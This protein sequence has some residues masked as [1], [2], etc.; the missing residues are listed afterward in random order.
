MSAMTEEE[1]IEF[2]K[3]K[4]IQENKERGYKPI[5]FTLDEWVDQIPPVYKIYRVEHETDKAILIRCIYDY[6]EYEG[7]QAYQNWYPK[8]AIHFKEV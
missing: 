7:Y 3:Q 5:D 8:K 1:R 6:S 2:M 4:H